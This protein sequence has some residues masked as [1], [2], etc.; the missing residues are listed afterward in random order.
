MDRTRRK[1]LHVVHP[2]HALMVAVVLM[3]MDV[4]NADVVR[5]LH[6]PYTATISYIHVGHAPTSFLPIRR[7]FHSAIAFALVIFKYQG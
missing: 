2:I 1:F 5:N 6:R 7:L 4:R 3:Y